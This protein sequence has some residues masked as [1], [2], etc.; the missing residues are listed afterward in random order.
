MQVA[1][2]QV[3]GRLVAGMARSYIRIR[4]GAGHARDPAPVQPT[5]MPPPPPASV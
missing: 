3:A 2:M 5:H 4:A 1:G